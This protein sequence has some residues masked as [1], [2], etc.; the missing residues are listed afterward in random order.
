[1]TKKDLQKHLE[2]I[3]ELLK[4]EKEVLVKNDGDAL[5][6]ILNKKSENIE[7][8]EEFKGA[9]L[10]DGQ[11]MDLIGEINSLQELNLLLTRQALSFGDNFL[12]S[13]AKVAKTDNTYQNTGSYDKS[14]NAN[15]IEKEV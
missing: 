9:D 1:M 6:E 8:L 15:I 3:I 2:S 14:T 11:I 10:E 13:L 5:I 7:M 4:M 12:E